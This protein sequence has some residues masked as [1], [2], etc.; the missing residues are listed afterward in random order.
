MEIVSP[1]PLM[2]LI[3][4]S[5]PHVASQITGDDKSKY[6]K[7]KFDNKTILYCMLRTSET[8]C[9]AKQ[10]TFLFHSQSQVSKLQF[11]IACCILYCSLVSHVAYYIAA[12]GSLQ[13]FSNHM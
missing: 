2:L 1:H 3:R 5:F 9:R 6:L 13:S 8:D 12:Q 10:F 11:S 4:S 7:T